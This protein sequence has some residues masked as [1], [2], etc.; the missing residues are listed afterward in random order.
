MD[1]RKLILCSREAMLDAFATA[2]RE[3]GAV[4]VSL[5]ELATLMGVGPTAVYSYFPDKAALLLAWSQREIDR[6]VAA[7]PQLAGQSDQ[8]CRRQ[9]WPGCC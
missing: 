5:R 3:R 2:I 4:K 1:L 7:L 8:A 6:F 9:L